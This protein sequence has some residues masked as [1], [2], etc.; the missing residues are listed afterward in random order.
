[1]GVIDSESPLG[2]HPIVAQ[3]AH[4]TNV[5]GSYID[6]SITNISHS[7]HLA[8][9][10]DY[11]LD[12]FEEHISKGAAH[13][14]AERGP[15]APQ[16]HPETRA[17]VQEEIMSWIGYGDQDEA[18]KPIMW[19]SGPAGS[20]KTAIAG[21]IAD[22][23][24]AKGW[25]AGSFFLSAF[26]GPPDRRSKRYF[27][28]TLAYHLVQQRS[29]PGI[30]NAILSAIA[31]TPSVFEKRLRDQMEI[32]ILQP[33]RT[34]SA[35]Q[36]RCS[37]PKVVVVD[38]LDECDA[39]LDKTFR[40]QQDRRRNQES[41]QQEIVSALVDASKDPTFPFRII[42]VSRPEPAIRDVIS[43]SDTAALCLFLDE[44]Y[45]PDADIAL[46]FNSKFSD[47]R[48]RF[49]IPTSWP[50]QQDLRVLVDRA[51][52]QFIYA[53]TVIRFVQAGKPPPEQLT[54]VLEWKN[55]D[56]YEAF[57]ALDALYLGIIQT[58]PDPPMATKWLLTISKI[59]DRPGMMF[60]EG[61]FLRGLLESSP[62]EME[63]LLGNLTSLIDLGPDRQGRSPSFNFYHKSLH[64]FLYDGRRSSPLH[65][66][67]PSPSKRYSPTQKIVMRFVDERMYQVFKGTT[68]NPHAK[69]GRG[70]QGAPA[71]PHSDD[72]E[73]AIFLEQL[74]SLLSDTISPRLGY[75]SD[76]V[77]WW[78]SCLS[79]SSSDKSETQCLTC[80]PESTKIAA[81]S[82]AL[83][84]AKSGGRAYC[85]TATNQERGSSPLPQGNSA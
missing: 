18:P 24:Q 61:W 25:L 62:G 75:S 9:V 58:S 16:C 6:N 4:V 50:S 66:E 3:N 67:L 80:L 53:A 11:R 70:P 46:F 5:E 47:I 38:G 59:P 72:S 44:K 63:Y 42:I 30:K 33:L 84:R 71:S 41:N 10:K 14:S 85:N 2:A 83:P 15:D 81:G 57:S 76:D 12:L 39:D 36:N 8:S 26:S 55:L 73:G 79:H 78:W 43:L 64:D 60:R 32:L 45:N 20:G 68:T 69:L 17:A 35:G 82:S 56:N 52:G 54:R 34:I 40:T 31:D 65:S 48:R 29:I 1:M 51:S 13:D 28:P 27:V 37:W 74:C 77:D 21:S 49:N 19:L 23:C 7:V 22:A